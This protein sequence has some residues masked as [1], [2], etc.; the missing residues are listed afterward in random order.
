[1]TTH[2]MYEVGVSTGILLAQRRHGIHCEEVNAAGST[3]AVAAVAVENA[4]PCDRSEAPGRLSAAPA[5][6]GPAELVLR[7]A[8][9]AAG[10][11]SRWVGI[12]GQ[13]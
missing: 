6:S 13:R 5:S 9:A 4:T 7:Y 2:L 11:E 8:T 3:M 12:H 10:G 1:M